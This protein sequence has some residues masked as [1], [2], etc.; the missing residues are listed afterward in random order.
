M[1][2]NA[3]D[4]FFSECVYED[5]LG[6]ELGFNIEHILSFFSVD[7]FV[8]ETQTSD[9]LNGKTQ[10]FNFQITFKVD[11]NEKLIT[12]L[13][14]EYI[15]IDIYSLRDDVQTIFG[16]GKISLKELTLILNL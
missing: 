8:H 12:Y 2:E 6:E 9:I 1:N 4:I 16:K 3:L 15:Y 11:M 10:Q 5:G 7:F 14:S 13:E